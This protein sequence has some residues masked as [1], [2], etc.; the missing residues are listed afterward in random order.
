MKLVERRRSSTHSVD[1]TTALQVLLD[2]SK[3][4]DTMSTW[5]YE[6]A[7]LNGQFVLHEESIASPNE[8]PDMGR[9]DTTAPFNGEPCEFDVLLGRGKSNTHHPGNQAFQGKLFII[10][11][12][13]CAGIWRRKIR[14]RPVIPCPHT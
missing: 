3:N 9:Q 13:F 10:L 2:D 8:E 12:Y 4:I 14:F 7:A 1:T 5:N 11:N 6:E